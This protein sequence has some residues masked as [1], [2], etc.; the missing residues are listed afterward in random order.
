MDDTVAELERLK[1]E[2]VRITMIG[3]VVMFVVFMLVLA[4]TA[5]IISWL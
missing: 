1:K 3:Y 4:G 5:V 2:W